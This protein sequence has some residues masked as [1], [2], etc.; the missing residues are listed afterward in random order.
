MIEFAIP[1]NGRAMSTIHISN[2]SILPMVANQIKNKES[3]LFYF[4]PSSQAS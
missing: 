2:I 1:V 4:I 3:A